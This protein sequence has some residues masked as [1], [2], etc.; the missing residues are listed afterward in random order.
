MRH[1][2]VSAHLASEH[3]EKPL[4]ALRCPFAACVASQSSFPQWSSPEG[5]INHINHFHLT[6][7]ESPNQEFLDSIG[8][9]ICRSCSILIFRS[10]CPSC[11]G[12]SR[13]VSEVSSTCCSAML[14]PAPHSAFT[15]CLNEVLRIKAPTIRHLPQAVRVRWTEAF[16]REVHFFNRRPNLIALTRILFFPKATLA[17]LSRGGRKK[18][19]QPR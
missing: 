3:P 8:C 12:R 6:R 11:R 19:A 18:K 1:A 14:A 17:G 10:G 7:G 15:A 2:D 4:P 13:E 5:L 9:S 16:T